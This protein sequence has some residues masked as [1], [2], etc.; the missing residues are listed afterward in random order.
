M[1]Q[2]VYILET[3]TKHVSMLREGGGGGAHSGEQKFKALLTPEPFPAQIIYVD[4]T[5]RQ[6]FT[7]D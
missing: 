2:L 4:T 7:C 3:T 6:Y 5:H 1:Q